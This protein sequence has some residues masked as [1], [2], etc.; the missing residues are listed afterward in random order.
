MM[1]RTLASLTALLGSVGILLL[2]A[3]LLGT[4]L[5]VRLGQEGVAATTIGL[6]MA[7]YSVGFVLAT[8]FCGQLIQRVGHIRTFAAMAAVA[9]CCALAHGLYVN[10]WLWA[11][12]RVV[13]GFALAG[14]YMVT[15]SWLNDRSPREIRGRVLSIYVI[16]TSMALGG[17]QLLLGL[18]DVGAHHLFS[19][20]AML[21]A[22]ALIPVA[23]ARA[24][25][26]EVVPAGRLGLWTLYTISPLA[27]VTSLGAGVIN[28]AFFA[29]GPAFAVLVGFG[30]GAAGRF[31]A[32]AIL[33]GL[34]LQ[35][36]IGR[37]SDSHDRRRVVIATGVG[38]AVTSVA[39]ALVYW[40][41]LAV[42][43]GLAMVWGG[44][45]FAL[46]AL[47]LSLVHD[48]T[49]PE[50]RGPAGATL[51]LVHGLGMIAGP[52][53][54][55]QLMAVLGAPGLF[56]G[57]AV[58]AMLIALFGY[59]RNRVGDAIDVATQERYRV[60]PQATVGSGYWT[61]L[62]GAGEDRQLEF[63]FTDDAGGDAW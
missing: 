47:A 5:S 50:E 41:S 25:S 9:A 16:V 58:V 48:F 2:G 35:Y 39:I 32:A 28:G 24:G 13:F 4:L 27:T 23:L 43:V 57:I 30:A 54:L 17:G 15:E 40:H 26:P 55:A 59:Y 19:V 49:A 42:L 37:L 21:L 22:A 7:C 31:M 56:V 29:L 20:A 53:L 45:N 46:Y 34:L 44:S 38:V 12:L 36:L 14:L 61:T 18:G 62:D 6:V 11:G 52:I 8:L 1:T 33:G 63:D 60:M 3:G 10:E 51:L